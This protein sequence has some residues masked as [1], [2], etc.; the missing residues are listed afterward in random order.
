M[1]E[2]AARKIKQGKSFDPEELEAIATMHAE[3]LQSL[4]LGVAIFVR[5][6]KNTARQLLDRKKLI[7]EIESRETELY[8]Q[9]LRGTPPRPQDD[10][11]LRVLRDLR[12]IHSYLAA[13]A[14]PVLD[15]GGGMHDRVADVPIVGP[16]EVEVPAS[17]G[18][19][20]QKSEGKRSVT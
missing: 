6:D 8:F 14:Y 17:R 20:A 7:W 5:G 19:A 4:E 12:R 15:H 11:C 2:F 10:F 9:S 1:T 18:E 13:L 16:R 3:V